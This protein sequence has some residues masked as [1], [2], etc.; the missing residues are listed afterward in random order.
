MQENTKIPLCQQDQQQG[1]SMFRGSLK[2]E[3]KSKIAHASIAGSAIL[4]F[5][6]WIPKTLCVDS[7]SIDQKTNM[8]E[9]LSLRKQKKEQLS[10][11]K[12]TY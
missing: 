3:G 6:W 11:R 1:V 2:T 9:Q 5:D 7:H 12:Q 10:L 8:R 4:A